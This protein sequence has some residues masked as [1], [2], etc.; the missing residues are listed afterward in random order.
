LLLLLLLLGAAA[1]Q[2]LP[3][4]L[5]AAQPLTITMQLIVAV[6]KAWRRMHSSH[7]NGSQVR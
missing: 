5:H 2:A 1:V 3:Q 7:K 6:L 4:L